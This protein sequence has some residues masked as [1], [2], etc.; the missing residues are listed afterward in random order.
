MLLREAIYGFES[1]DMALY[2]TAARRRLA[3]LVGGDE[4]KPLL[5]QTDAWMRDN[6]V[7]NPDALTAMVAP[8]Y[9]G[10]VNAGGRVSVERER[11]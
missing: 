7:V 8:G 5:A 11:A 9:G 2:A 3:Q 4:G 1:A 6:G 10:A